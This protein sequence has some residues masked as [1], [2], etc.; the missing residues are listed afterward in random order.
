[1][2]T[3]RALADKQF[4][5]EPGLVSL[6]GRI[7]GATAGAGK[8]AIL[9]VDGIA[10]AGAFFVVGEKA[11]GGTSTAFG[12]VI[13]TITVNSTTQLLWL[14]GVTGGPFQNNENV[15]GGGTGSGVVDGIDHTLPQPISGG[16]VDYLCMVVDFTA[17]TKAVVNEVLTGGTT[18]A[19][20]R[21]FDAKTLTAT[22][23]LVCMRGLTGTFILAE[24]LSGSVAAVG[25]VGTQAYYRTAYNWGKGITSVE[26]VIST[27]GLGLFTITLEDTRCGLLQ[28]KASMIDAGTVDDW[29]VTPQVETVATA[30]TITCAVFK[31][32][33]AA[34]L[35]G[36][37]Q[38]LLEIVTARNNRAPGGF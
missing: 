31:G 26:P 33:A 2:T 36:N 23:Q 35:T 8:M 22:T 11:T 13:K 15:T 1:M 32:G 20:G 17:G 5:L 6:F 37:Q 4:S 7:K 25:T 24:A 21:V 19:T 18:G 12:V 28:F 16:A 34:D 14:N 30:K 10:S 3:S 38:M 27:A 9:K 29:E